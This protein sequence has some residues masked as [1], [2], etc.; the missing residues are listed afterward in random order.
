M[1]LL[2]TDMQAGH[3][4]SAGRSSGISFQA[5]RYAL[6]IEWLKEVN[7]KRGNAN[8]IGK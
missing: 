4:P 5:Y 3:G 2:T 8:L 7:E 6:L 1:I